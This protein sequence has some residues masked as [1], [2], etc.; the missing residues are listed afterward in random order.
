MATLNH[1]LTVNKLHHNTHLPME[2]RL[3]KGFPTT[4]KGILKR[5]AGGDAAAIRFVSARMATLASHS[6]SVQRWCKWIDR[7]YRLYPPG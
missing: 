4:V 5:Y 3:N 2:G 7:H 6:H 1:V